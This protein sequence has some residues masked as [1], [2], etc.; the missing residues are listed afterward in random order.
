[1]FNLLSCPGQGSEVHFCIQSVERGDET[2]AQAP[3]SLK[4]AS[5]Q[6]GNRARGDISVWSHRVKE[7]R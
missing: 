6:T 1:M 5:L 7:A 2:L 3:P 4:P